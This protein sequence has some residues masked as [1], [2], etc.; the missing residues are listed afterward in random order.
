V[1][2]HCRRVEHVEPILTL[3]GLRLV[4]ER[5]TLRQDA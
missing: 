1:V 2:K 3:V 4:F 5:N